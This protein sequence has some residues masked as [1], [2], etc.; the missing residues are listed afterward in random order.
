MRIGQWGT[1]AALVCLPATSRSSSCA[2]AYQAAVDHYSSFV[3][4]STQK[5]APERWEELARQ[6]AAVAE[7]YPACHRA[8]DALFTAGKLR[9]ESYQFLKQ[10]D[11]LRAAAAT[12][13][14][15]IQK[16]PA[17]F[18]ADDAQFF[19]GRCYELLGDPAQARIEY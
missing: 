18:L 4:S 10:P 5:Q 13:Q 2:S 8:D 15:L 7:K 3:S 17:S 14:T 11:Q 9:F 16:Y 12:F 19:R 6:F 1:I